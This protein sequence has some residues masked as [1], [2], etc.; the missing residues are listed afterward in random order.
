MRDECAARSGEPPSYRVI[1][2]PLLSLNIDRQ[3]D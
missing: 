1:N 3:T 2:K